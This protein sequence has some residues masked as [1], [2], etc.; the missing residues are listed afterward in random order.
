MDDNT[1]ERRARKVDPDEAIAAV[2]KIDSSAESSR[3]YSDGADRPIRT[4]LYRDKDTERT[5]NMI[6]RA[7]RVNS[8][9]KMR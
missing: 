3:A 8:F 9:S 5:I 1:K 6:A 4:P 2:R 7:S